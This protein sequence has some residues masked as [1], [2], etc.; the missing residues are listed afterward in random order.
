[1]PARLSRLVI[2]SSASLLALSLQAQALT[3]VTVALPVNL[4]LANWPFYVADAQ[5]MFAAEGLEV[6]MQGLDGSS[7]AIQAT[8]AGQAQVA[9]TAPAD[10]LAASGAGADVTGFYNFYQYLPFRLVTTADSPIQSLADIR[11]KS[12]GISSAGGGEAIFARSLL[13]NAG[14]EEGAYEELMVG[15]GSSA[16]QALSGGVVDVFSAS[17]VDEIIFG[18][19]GL[20]VRP[21]ESEGYPATTGELLMAETAWMQAHPEAVLGLGRGLARATAA[22]LADRDLVVQTCGAVAPH[23]TEDLG[24]TTAVL[25]GVD[26]LFTLTTGEDYGYI[27]PEAWAAYRALIVQIGVAGPTAAETEVFNADVAAWNAD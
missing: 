3:Q 2:A 7:S 13:T 14:I 15:E 12:V 9:A 5:G 11:G 24:F 18:G 4:C 19:M 20:G 6:T 1:M 8:L 21:L 16:G 26:P 25:N 10:M 17:F 22:G 23:E 27:D